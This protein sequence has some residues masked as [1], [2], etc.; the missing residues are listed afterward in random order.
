[1]RL[2]LL[3]FFSFF[4]GLVSAQRDMDIKVTYANQ[5]ASLEEIFNDLEQQYGI[6]FSYATSSIR[7]KTMNAAFEN[8]SI[9]RVLDYLLANESMEYKIVANNVLLKKTETYSSNE[10]DSYKSSL[11]IKG[12]ITNSNEDKEALGFATISISNSS[13]GTYS[14]E[15]GRFD[16][17]IPEKYK[18]E[19]V[20]IHYIG[21]EDEV[22][23]ISELKDE[24]LL[25][26][27]KNGPVSID[28]ITIVNREKPLKIG[29]NNGGIQL[30]KTQI[31]STTS[32][33]MGKDIARQIQLLP[34]IA[35]HEDNSA[36]IK[37][38]GSNEDETLMVLDG[39]PIYNANHY[40]GIFSS[41]NAEYIDSVNIYKNT[42]P[43]HYGGKT[44]GLV[45]L[46][47]ENSQPEKV[48]GNVAIDLM[49]ATAEMRIP[50][51]VHS[52][53]SFAGRSTIREVNNQQFNT[54][55]NPFQTD[56]LVQNFSQMVNDQKNDPDFTFYDFNAK[57]Q[58]RNQKDDVFS[59]NFYRSADDVNNNF[60][61]AIRDVNDN[62]L[63][64]I[65]TDTE[66]WSNTAASMLFSKNISTGS[67]WNSTVFFTQYSNEE[68]NDLKLDKK[69][70]KGGPMPQG[71]PDMADLSSDQTNELMDF[72][73]D[74]HLDFRLGPGMAKI[75][76][77]T[78]YHDIEYEFSDNRKSKLAGSDEFYEIAGYAGYDFRLG[79][80]IDV[81]TGLRST[82]FTNLR[83][84]KFSPRIL[85]NYLASDQIA[86]KS[87]FNIENQV[88]RQFDFEYRGEPMA[89]WVSSGGNDIP[90]LRSHNYMVG[91]T[92]KLNRFAVD[93]ELYQKNINGQLEYLLPNLGE[94]SNTNEQIREYKLFRGD[95]LVRGIDVILSSG[96]KN[97]DTYI[98]YTLSKSQQ[99]FKEI[100]Q[101]N[102][103]SSENDRTHQ[104]KWVNTLTTGNFTWGLNGIY[105]SGRPY[106]EIRNFEAQQD[107]RDLD[108]DKRLKRLPAYHRIDVSAAYSFSIGSYKA[109]LFA[110][111]FNLLNTENVQYIQA[112][113]TDFN[114]DN[115][116]QNIVVGN[117]SALLNRTLNLGFQI[118]F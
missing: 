28:E 42:Y 72:G 103:F 112:V 117:E 80:S 13:V 82:Y 27:L 43:L 110:S 116:I 23:K 92:V 33:L 95:G 53:L 75:G 40:Y 49:T 74:S 50:L 118:G 78:T 60:R 55:T 90:V 14:D 21:F 51:S 87:S 113:A 12:K 86:F 57:Y 45:E 30:N 69:R 96:Y 36:A 31:G 76:M 32:G 5:D 4:T 52:N 70:K 2:A 29:G 38:R 18:N 98:S 108:P 94:S 77:M 97:Y 79:R 10:D 59:L 22:Y 48:E 56:A 67:R 15:E 68:V 16:I 100:F 63:K 7:H 47:S 19:N 99:R 107:P 6:R 71:L 39:M 24:F 62:E 89:L 83:A 109:S 35:A 84:T 58:Y 1:M 114:S 61:T 85:V 73:I 8:E 44:A 106:T 41:L 88:I 66:S 101:N 11:H 25:V 81:S 37:I 46:F 104:L 9:T 17:E 54:A 102:Y 91:T 20:V 115:K 93:V 3:L 34:G 65:G 105:V 26:S 111:V 64:L